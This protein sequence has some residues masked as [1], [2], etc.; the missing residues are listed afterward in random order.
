PEALVKLYTYDGKH[1][2][3]PKDFDTIG[4]FYNKKIFKD[5]GVELPTADWTWDDFHDKAKKISDW[6]KSKGIYGCA[7]TINGDGQGT[8]Y[9]T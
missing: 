8:Y 3:V 4:V 9:N 2:G 7:T 5:A 1:Y 6:G